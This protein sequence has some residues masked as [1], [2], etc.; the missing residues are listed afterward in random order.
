MSDKPL[1]EVFMDMVN[2]AIDE[3][4]IYPHQMVAMAKDGGLQVHAMM[5][6][7][8][9]LVQYFWNKLGDSEEVIVGIDMST[10]PDQGTKYADALVIAYWRR[11]PDKKLTDPS[12]LKIGVVNYQNEPRIIDPID[13]D[14]DH[15]DHWVRSVFPKYLP[16]FLIRVESGQ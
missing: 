1:P 11:D 15:W 6:D 3:D 12:C 16:P 13:W 5:V 9:N 7:L 2:I 8:P 10:R 4:G 14:N